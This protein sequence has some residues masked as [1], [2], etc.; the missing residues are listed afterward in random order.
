M[1][2]SLFLTFQDHSADQFYANKNSRF[3]ICT[4]PADVLR[5]KNPMTS[6]LFNFSRIPWLTIREELAWQHYH[7]DHHQT[8]YFAWKIVALTSRSRNVL[9]VQFP[10]MDP[11]ES[12]NKILRTMNSSKQ[13]KAPTAQDFQDALFVSG[14]PLRALSDQNIF[15]TAAR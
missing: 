1:V 14:L 12:E 7:D 11:L 2:M 13:S 4:H 5:C 9:R 3:Q 8:T 6:F 10:A 15:V